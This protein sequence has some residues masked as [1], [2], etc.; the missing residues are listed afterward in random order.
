HANSDIHCVEIGYG[1]EEFECVAGDTQDQVTVEGG[2]EVE[3]AFGCCLARC[4]FGLVEVA[5]NLYYVGAEGAHGSILVRRISQRD[6]EC[7]G[8]A[9]TGRCEGNRLT[10]IAAGGRDHSGDS[11]L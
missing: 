1:A 4:M 2:D 10:V 9:G 3:V 5:A 6:I 8:Y 7:R 11:G